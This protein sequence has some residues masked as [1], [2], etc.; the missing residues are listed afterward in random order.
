[1]QALR[2]DVT[3]IEGRS[4]VRALGTCKPSGIGT[5]ATAHAL[6][7]SKKSRARNGHKMGTE[8]EYTLKTQSISIQ[9]ID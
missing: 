5:E 2:K 9:V 6:E 3:G 4:K 7:L 1:M 8:P